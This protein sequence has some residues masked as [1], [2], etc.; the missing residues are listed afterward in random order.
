MRDADQEEYRLVEAAAWLQGFKDQLAI[1]I[2]K[3]ML[4]REAAQP[5]Q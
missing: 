2:A 5:P 4:A 3:I 1:S